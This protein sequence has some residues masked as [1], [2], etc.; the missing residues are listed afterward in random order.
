MA[1]SILLPYA[2]LLGLVLLALSFNVVRLRR[3]HQVGIGT[4][5]VPE[6]ARG[7]RAHAN[8]CEYV[9]LA[10]VLLFGLAVAG[11]APTWA[12][13]VLGGALLVG[14]VLHAIGLSRT[15]GASAAP[16][17]RRRPLGRTGGRR[18]IVSA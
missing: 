12:L 13:H 4:G 16:G 15:A 7:I 18:R 1:A 3:K 9:P 2:G 10:L 17:L 5:D 8:F 14:R 11:A 6:L